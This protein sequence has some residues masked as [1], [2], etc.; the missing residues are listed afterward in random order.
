MSEM[1]AEKLSQRLLDFGLVDVDHLDRVWGQLGSRDASVE[2]LVSLLLRKELLTNFQIERLL[3]GERT[4]YF[5]GPYRVLYMIGTG[6]FARVYRAVHREKGRVMAV[7]VLRRRYREEPP[8]VEQFLREARMGKSLRHPNIVAIYDVATENRAPYMV[9]EFVE[10]Q[11]LREMIRV[12]KKIEPLT[13]TRFLA[14]V[15]A[16]LH[17]AGEQGITHRDL[18]MSNVL[19]SSRGRAKLVDFGLAAAVNRDSEE[20]LADCPNARAIDYASLERGTGVRK[21][22]PRSDIYFAGCLYY[23]M[24]SGV[25]P[26]TETRDRLQRLNVSRFREVKPIAQREPHL[27]KPVVAV[28]N[29]AMELDPSKRYPTPAALLADTQEVADLLESGKLTAPDEGDTPLSNGEL[30]PAEVE[31]I[32][33]RAEGEGRTVLIVESKVE[34]QNL[35]REALKKRGYRVLV[36]GDPRR[37]L[38]RFDAD[39]IDSAAD[40]VLF[41]TQELSGEALEAFNRFG[42]APLTRDIPAILLVD[43]KQQNIMRRAKL[44]SHRLM[45]KMPL[46]V[47]Q[48]RAACTITGIV[49]RQARCL[50][51]RGAPDSRPLGVRI[52][53][54]VPV[55]RRRSAESINA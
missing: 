2:D 46:K 7:K 37:A 5:Y 28:L 29:R 18:K 52:G 3:K 40:C 24:L 9:M 51:R 15:A 8:Q 30:A 13:A 43:E 14:D 39:A 31:A 35:L 26:L 10:G 45:L 34:M 17:Y 21:D 19:I 4:G 38:A 44:S 11:N 33:R 36:I 12:R 25:P 1:T 54:D 49:R 20:A 22:D 48:L 50:Q 53:N 23:H 41:S 6:T 55:A 27:P 16:A 47:R 32:S 42:E